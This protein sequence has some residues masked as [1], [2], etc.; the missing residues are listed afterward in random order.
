MFDNTKPYAAGF[1]IKGIPHAN[2]CECVDCI[3]LRVAAF[4]KFYK[5]Q[6]KLP[7][8]PDKTRTVFVR[9]HWRRNPHHLA[10]MPKYRKA[11]IKEFKG[12]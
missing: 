6:S 9:P 3:P 8:M 4:K 5:E 10:K 1:V 2:C 7:L 12:W 11:L